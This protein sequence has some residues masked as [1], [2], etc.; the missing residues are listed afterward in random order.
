[1]TIKSKSLIPS[2]DDLWFLP[3]GGSGE[4]GMNLNLYGH[5]GSWLMVDLGITFHDRLGLEVLTPNPEFIAENYERLAG[6]V[7]TH[8]HEDHVGAVPYLWQALRCPV[9]ATGFTATVLRQKLREVPWGNQVPIIEIPLSGQVT[10][11]PFHIEFITLTHSIPEP[12]ALAITTPLGR[13]V[14]TGDWKLDDAPLIGAVSDSKR[15]QALGDE[16]VLA[17]VCDSTNVFT[18][19]SSGSE[20]EV[21]QN[22]TELMASHADK[23]L[24]LACFS[25]NIARVQTIIQAGVAQGRQIALLGRSL[26]K[27]VEAAQANGYLQNVPPFINEESAMRLPR[28]KVLI[29]S[30]GSQGESRS[31]L[32]R[33]AALTHPRISLGPDDVVIFSSRIIP[34]NEKVIGVMQNRLVGQGV[35]IIIAREGDIHVSGHPARDELKQMYAWTRPQILV[36]VHGELLHMQ[37]QAALGISCGIPTA[38]V[39]HNGGIIQ[40]VG[41]NKGPVADVVAGRLAYDGNR[42]IPWESNSLRD[43]QRL[44]VQGAVVATLIIDSQGRLARPLQ[45]TLWGLAA[46]DEEADL[47]ETAIQKAVQRTLNEGPVTKNTKEALRVTIRRVISEQLDKKPLADVHLIQL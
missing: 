5:D 23:R 2:K 46:D 8:A 35:Q 36:P 34:G 45:L 37:A 42:L 20:E 15:L 6:L 11:G 33:V 1:M 13:I 4:I 9:Y 7:L 30:T 17:L 39:P 16:G 25:S 26:Q 19:G 40:L 47:L 28:E 18:A 44:S 12:N 31:A 22:L 43:R 14:H 41:K 3:L 21:R 27:M 29:L 38:L 10:I 24:V 32:A